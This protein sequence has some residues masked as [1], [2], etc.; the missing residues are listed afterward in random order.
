MDY[1]LKKDISYGQYAQIHCGTDGTMQIKSVYSIAMYPMN[2]REEYAF[3]SLGT[4]RLLH[5]NN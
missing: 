3:M 1:D 5:S 2:K 4:V